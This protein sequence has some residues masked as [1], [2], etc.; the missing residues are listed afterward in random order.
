[1]TPDGLPAIGRLP[2]HRNVFVAAGHNMLGLVLAPSTGRLVAEL[3]G[4]GEASAAFDPRRIA[5]AY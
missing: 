4:G 3:V 2:R 1:M 5:R